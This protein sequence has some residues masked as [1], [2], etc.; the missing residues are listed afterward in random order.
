MNKSSIS[1]ALRVA[2]VDSKRSKIGRL[3]EV[4]EDVVAAQFAGVSNTKI[5]ETLKSQGLNLDLK[6]F[7]TMM[8]RLR[9]E[10]G[11][12]R[13]SNQKLTI[14]KELKTTLVSQ[15]ESK[16]KEFASNERG[17]NDAGQGLKIG[18]KPKTFEH[19]PSPDKDNLL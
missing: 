10:L 13:I 6:S 3:R 17:R 16:T 9:K 12:A 4:F 18:D 1:E 14:S 15:T 8:Y 5:V 19:D 2:A 7:E 11:K